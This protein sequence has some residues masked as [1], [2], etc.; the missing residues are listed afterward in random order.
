MK[1]YVTEFANDLLRKDREA[2]LMKQHIREERKDKIQQ[3]VKLCKR[4]SIS[5][6]EAMRALAEM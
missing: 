3:I 4:G 6:F 2:K 5:E 1:R